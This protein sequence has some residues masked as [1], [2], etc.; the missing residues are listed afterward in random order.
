MIRLR[1]GVEARTRRAAISPLSG[2]AKIAFLGDSITHGVGDGGNFDGFRPGID[3]QLVSAGFSSLVY[4][5]PITSG[6]VAKTQNHNGHDS[7]T[8][9]LHI[10]EVAG[11]YG[12]G[13]IQPDI[14]AIQLGTNDTNTAFRNA[15]NGYVALL[16]LLHTLVPTA[17]FV[18]WPP[19]PRGSSA[20]VPTNQTDLPNFWNI[21]EG[22]GLII[23]RAMATASALTLG[24]GTDYFEA[25]P[26]ETHPNATGYSKLVTAIYPAFVR[27][28]QGAAMP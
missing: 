18:C 8:C 13:L 24:A 6:T 21:L 3:A 9:A 1:N 12:P 14:F 4:Q 27:A 25:N 26:N 7:Y 16:R 10:A 19:P 20:D 15:S 22:E 11:F 23:Y 28:L 17:R 5:G 2:S